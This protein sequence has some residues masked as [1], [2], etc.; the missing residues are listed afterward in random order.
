MPD[1]RISQGT[2]IVAGFFEK[3]TSRVQYVVSDP[4]IKKCA[5]ID[6]VLDFDPNSG[7]TATHSADELLDHIKQEK[8]QLQWILDTPHADHFSAAGYLKELR[9]EYPQALARK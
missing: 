5:I 7:A 6:P 2:P 8:C 9:P 3:H 4:K 1:I